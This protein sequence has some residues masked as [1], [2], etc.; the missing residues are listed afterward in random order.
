MATEKAEFSA[1]NSKVSKNIGYKKSQNDLQCRFSHNQRCSSSFNDF[2]SGS[3]IGCAQ[4]V[5]S[6]AHVNEKR[7]IATF[8]VALSAA[9]FLLVTKS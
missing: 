7:H 3:V 1:S 8:L 2:S 9:V 4:H 6:P 5:L